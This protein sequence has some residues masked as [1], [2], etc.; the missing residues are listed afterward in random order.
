MPIQQLD[1]AHQ[2]KEHGSLLILTGIT[3][4]FEW[5][6]RIISEKS[7]NFSEQSALDDFIQLLLVTVTLLGY[8]KIDFLNF[9]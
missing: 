1:C 4:K 3:R 7:F 9:C 2:P 8:R 5:P 6:S